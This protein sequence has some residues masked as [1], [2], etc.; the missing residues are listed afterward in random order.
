MGDEIRVYGEIIDYVI[1]APKIPGWKFYHKYLPKRFRKHLVEKFGEKSEIGISKNIVTNVGLALLAQRLGGAS[2]NPISHIAIGTSSSTPMAG[3]T[4]LGAEVYRQ[5]ASISYI[6]TSVSND[7]VKAEA[8]FSITGTY[9]LR[10]VGTFNASSGGTMYN[11]ALLATPRSV[12]NGD[13]EYV[14]V[15][16]IMSRQ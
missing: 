3:D 5:S 8:S 11:R 6:T 10:E 9:T 12:V 14:T 7:T 15:K 16:L 2:V 4:A 1:K 13:T